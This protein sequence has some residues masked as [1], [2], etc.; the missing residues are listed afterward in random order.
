LLQ[1]T[2]DLWIGTHVANLSMISG[3]GGGTSQTQI[4]I[5]GVS[6]SDFILTTDQSVG[7]YVDGVNY[8]RSLGAALDLLDGELRLRMNF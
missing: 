6:Q 8:P 4:S 5:R 3:Q 1:V 7:M 2:A